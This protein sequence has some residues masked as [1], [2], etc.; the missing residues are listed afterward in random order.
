MSK[1]Y[2]CYGYP[3]SH[4]EEGLNILKNSFGTFVNIQIKNFEGDIL[5][6]HSGGKI[7][8]EILKDKLETH[9]YY[10]DNLKD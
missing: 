1:N 6:E 2:C 8:T 7:F 3:K 5:F 10:L 9:L 4:F